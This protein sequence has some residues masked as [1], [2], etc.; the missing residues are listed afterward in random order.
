MV[1]LNSSEAVHA[2]G[3]IDRRSFLRLSAVV[4]APFVT[5]WQGRG[6]AVDPVVVVGAGLAGLRAAEVLRKAGTPVVALEARN[7][8]GGRVYTIRSPFAEGLYAEAGAIRIPP[9]HETV[10][11]LAKDHHLNLVPFESFNGSALATIGNVTARI[12]DD[13]KKATA[14][15]ALKPEEDG[16]SQAALLARYVTDL[17][18]DMG[19]LK[20]AADAYE[21]W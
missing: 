11:Q 18:S 10:I 7:R 8:P 1:A 17:P 14:T 9:Q 4:A 2:A 13:L 20:P 3:A 15:L 16:L 21:R 5:R 12:P 6:A 19:E